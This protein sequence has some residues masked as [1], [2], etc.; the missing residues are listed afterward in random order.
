LVAR[1]KAVASGQS[2][3][4]CRDQRAHHYDVSTEIY[5]LFLDEDL[6][7]S[8]GFFED[9]DHDTLERAQANKLRRATL[10]LRLQPEMNVAEI[11]SGWGSFAI[12][13]AATTGAR[14]TA[15]NVSPEQIRVA[16]QRAELAGVGDRVEFR[17]MDYRH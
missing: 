4:R 8:C 10:K 12:H 16:R 2:G 14:V 7:Y 1:G 3:G 15:V 9:P 11:G 5:R 17:E 6:N 13:I